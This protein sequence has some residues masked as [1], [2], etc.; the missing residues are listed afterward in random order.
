MLS[1]I[2]V[3]FLT[4]YLLG[5]VNGSVAV[6]SLL[7]HSD[8]RNSGS[9]NA[10]LT[11]FLRTYGLRHSLP[12]ILTDLVKAVLA[13]SVG[14]M[15]LE[16]HGFRLEGVLLG[17]LA[18]ALGHDF[19]A[20]L[21]FRGGKGVMCG[22]GMALVAD[23]RLFLLV[24]AAF[25]LGLLLTRYVSVG[26]MLCGI[27]FPVAVTLWYPHRIWAVVLAWAAGLLL[28]FMHRGNL[29]RVIRGTESKFSIRKRG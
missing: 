16:P 29:V 3:I 22:A 12:V 14:A 19:P 8:V 17:G 26:S 20:A 4:G 10:G 21:G 24:L 15:L 11:N 13:C 7:E 5:N 2:L 27:T 25:A 28:L 23:W 1:K 6:S 18:V 9:G